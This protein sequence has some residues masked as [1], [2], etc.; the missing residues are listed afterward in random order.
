VERVYS[1]TRKGEVLHA[2]VAAFKSDIVPGVIVCAPRKRFNVMYGNVFYESKDLGP[3]GTNFQEKTQEQIKH[4]LVEDEKREER[5]KDSHIRDQELYKLTGM[6]SRKGYSVKF[7]DPIPYWKT[8]KGYPKNMTDYEVEM[9]VRE[10]FIADGNPDKPFDIA[11][12]TQF[13]RILVGLVCLP[14]KYDYVY[15]TINPERPDEY[16]DLPR[17]EGKTVRDYS[18]W[19]NETNLVFRKTG[20][21]DKTHYDIETTTRCVCNIRVEGATYATLFVGDGSP[22]SYK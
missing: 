10:A 3:L 6:W 18:C 1:S 12:L 2:C 9:L 21:K 15:R 22:K 14:Y 7:R 19:N 17:E 8:L 16:A 4:E 5:R 11:E 20:K 13:E